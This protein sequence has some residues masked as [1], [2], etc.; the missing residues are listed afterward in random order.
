MLAAQA[1]LLI[2]SPLPSEEVL[3][4]L[5]AATG[6]RKWRGLGPVPHLFE[7]EI[8]GDRVEIRRV[9]GYNNG[10]LPRI[11]A[12]VE[13]TPEGSRI[14]GTLSM[15]PLATAFAAAWFGFLVVLATAFAVGFVREGMEDPLA[16]AIPFVIGLSGW[17]MQA[18]SFAYEARRAR[19]TL[20]ALLGA[21]PESPADWRTLLPPSNPARAELPAPPT[22]RDDGLVAGARVATAAPA[23]PPSPLI[24][25]KGGIDFLSLALLPRYRPTGSVPLT[26]PPGRRCAFSCETRC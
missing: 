26:H 8:R 7:G 12:D 1:T 15:H 6:P 2:E 23:R 25:E 24:A 19:K 17:A 11:E 10:S 20:A 4:R 18:G 14:R 21:A 3:A 22:P 5:R 9:I 13:P 16:L